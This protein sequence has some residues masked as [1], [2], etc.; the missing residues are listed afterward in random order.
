[1]SFLAVPQQRGGAAVAKH[2]VRAADRRAPFH[3]KEAQTLRVVDRTDL[4][5][6]CPLH[7]TCLTIVNLKSFRGHRQLACGPSQGRS[8][9][10]RL[11]PAR[12]PREM[13]IPSTFTVGTRIANPLSAAKFKC[14]LTPSAFCSASSVHHGLAFVHS[15]QC[16]LTR[17]R[18]SACAELLLLPAPPAECA[19]FTGGFHRCWLSSFLRS[20]LSIDAKSSKTGCWLS[21]AGRK[22]MT[23]RACGLWYSIIVALAVRPSSL[24]SALSLSP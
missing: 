13:H 20:R 11:G 12:L 18:G 23:G 5:H 15:N 2:V 19:I 16:C 21:A 3:S 9:R 10:G 4:R 7:K 22:H 6:S 8:V 1:M 24:S 17:L 14:A